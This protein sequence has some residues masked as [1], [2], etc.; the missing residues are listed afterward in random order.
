MIEVASTGL[1]AS[2]VQTILTEVGISLDRFT[3]VKHFCS[4]L[5]LAPHNDISRGKVLHAHVLKGVNRA[6]QVFRLAAQSV[7]RSDSE[8]GAY[9]RRMRAKQ[10][11]KKAIVAT[12]H[13]LARAFYFMLKNRQAYRGQSAAQSETRE[14][15][16]EIARLTRKAKMLGLEIV[17][18]APQ[19]AAS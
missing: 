18:P 6:G 4:W 17:Q 12:A 10:G 19:P 5:H 14:R 7:S 15:E 3:D 1:N 8:F 9:F 16:R 11:P 2:S 13:K